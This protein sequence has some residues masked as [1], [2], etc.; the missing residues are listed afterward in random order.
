MQKDYSRNSKHTPL[1]EK[2]ALRSIL[3]R[4][5]SYIFVKLLG[6]I[7]AEMTVEESLT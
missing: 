6:R 7:K 2:V 4:H 5:A 1:R 3:A